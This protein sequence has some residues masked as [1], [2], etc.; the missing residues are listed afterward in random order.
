VLASRTVLF[1][2]RCARAIPFSVATC[3][4]LKR[5]RQTEMQKI[6]SDRALLKDLKS[7]HILCLRIYY[8][9]KVCVCVCVCVQ[10]EGLVYPQHIKEIF[11]QEKERERL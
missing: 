1:L 5:T 6:I 4:I 8:R 7:P 10:R 2:K 11:V 3:S 9:E